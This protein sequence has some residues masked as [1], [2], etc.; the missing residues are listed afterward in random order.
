[1]SHTESLKIAV[2]AGVLI[3]QDKKFLLVQEKKPA[4]RGQWN[5]PAGKVD[6]GE[7]LEQA[8]VREAKEETGFDVKLGRQLGIWHQT[9]EWPVVHIFTASITGGLLRFPQ[10]ELLDARWLTATQVREMKAQVRADFVLEAVEMV[11]QRS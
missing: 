5:L 10:H 4:V 1:M 9:L 7:T 2:V 3:F 11:E 8:A 6:L